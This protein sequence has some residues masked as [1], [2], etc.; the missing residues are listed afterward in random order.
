MPSTPPPGIVVDDSACH[1]DDLAPCGGVAV[2]TP[3][4]QDWDTFVDLAVDSSWPGLEALGGAAETVAGAVREEATRFG[5]EVFAAVASVRTWDRAQDRQQTLA[6][7]DCGFGTDR[8]RLQETLPGGDLRYE[9]LEVSWLFKLGDLT[10]PVRDP[11]LARL[12]A[13]EPGARVPLA[14]VLD[15][16]PAS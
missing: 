12:L 5:Q 3:G 6:W 15:V 13:V 2:L 10:A 14:G 7:G 16:I 11:E 9:M 1:V 4:D 8:P